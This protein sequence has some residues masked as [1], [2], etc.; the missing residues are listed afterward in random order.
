ML[1]VAIEGTGC[2]LYIY[3]YILLCLGQIGQF[4]YLFEAL[5]NNRCIEGTH[6]KRAPKTRLLSMFKV[7]R[8][9]HTR[10][11]CKP[12]C[13]LIVPSYKGVHLALVVLS[14]CDKISNM[15][16]AING[17]PDKALPIAVPRAKVIRCL[18]AC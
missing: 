2:W 3:T 7:I 10:H 1:D 5:Q 4:S 18:L 17:T 15:P 9:F 16:I 8:V 11:Y 14:L 6:Y 13:M 12:A